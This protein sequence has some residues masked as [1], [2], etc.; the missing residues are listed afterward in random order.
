M[1]F[2]DQQNVTNHADGFL[3]K[4]TILF[5]RF[6]STIFVIP[7]AQCLSNR[8]NRKPPGPKDFRHHQN[9]CHTLLVEACHTE[10]WLVT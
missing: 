8:I 1:N 7:Y 2:V 5:L 6:S 4:E 3:I 10:G 9:N